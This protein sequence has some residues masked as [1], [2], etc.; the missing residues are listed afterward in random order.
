MSHWSGKT[1]TERPAPSPDPGPT[2]DDYL[3]AF[4]TLL[5]SG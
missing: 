2:L 1:R 5:P 3:E 4:L